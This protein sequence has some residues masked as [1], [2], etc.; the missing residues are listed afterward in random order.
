VVPTTFLAHAT[1]VAAHVRTSLPR[2][3]QDTAT[4]CGTTRY[5]ASS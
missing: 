4:L 5:C 2:T 3:F 1:T